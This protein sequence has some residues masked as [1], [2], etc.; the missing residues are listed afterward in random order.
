MYSKAE[1][2]QERAQRRSAVQHKSR[3]KIARE[4]REKE[5]MK[6][7][8]KEKRTEQT[9]EQKKPQRKQQPAQ[10]EVESRRCTHFHSDADCRTYPPCSPSPGFPED[11]NFPKLVYRYFPPSPQAYLLSTG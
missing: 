7:Q 4:K 1:S 2:E 10:K 6:E 5:Q 11:S 9:K 8:T 3:N